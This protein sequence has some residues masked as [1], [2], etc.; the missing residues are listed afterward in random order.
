MRV[1]TQEED[2]LLNRI[3]S[4]V[5]ENY[6]TENEIMLSESQIKGYKEI[7]RQKTGKFLSVLIT[8]AFLIILSVGFL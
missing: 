7:R 3:S 1:A 8:S 5:N 4:L 2:I 6:L